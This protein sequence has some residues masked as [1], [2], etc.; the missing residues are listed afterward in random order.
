VTSRLIRFWTVVASI[1]IAVALSGTIRGDY[2]LGAIRE[3]VSRAFLPFR[4]QAAE[5]RIVVRQ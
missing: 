1:W 3:A 5:L 2:K 4:G